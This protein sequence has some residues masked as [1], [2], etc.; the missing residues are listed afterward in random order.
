MMMPPP[1]GGAPP[2]PDEPGL[3]PV[4]LMQR[5]S[6]AHVSPA[7]HARYSLQSARQVLS[8]PQYVPGVHSL[9]FGQGT[10]TNPG[11]ALSCELL[12][13]AMA[14]AAAPVTDRESV[15]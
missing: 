3:E 15:G 10:A 11:N 14:H 2:P 5:P 13:Q 4:V 6:P 1:V 9:P 7:G 12:L 8:G